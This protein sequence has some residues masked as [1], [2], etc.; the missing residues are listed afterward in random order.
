[1]SPASVGTPLLWTLFT[2]FVFFMLA[3]DLGVF[4]RRAHAVRLR[5]AAAW[6]AVWVGLAV[7][8]NLGVAHYFGSQKA[9]EFLTGYLIEWS[10]SV[11]NLFVFLVVFSYFNVPSRCQHRLLFWGILGALGMRAVLIAA[12]SLLVQRFHWILYVF[13]VILVV[14]ALRLLLS[15]EE[16][17]HPE[18]NP[19]VRLFRRLYP[20]TKD[21]EDC[22]LFVR[23]ER[24]W[25]AT[26]LFVVL[27]VVETTDLVF[28]LDSIPAIFAVTTDPFII[29]TSNVFAILGLRSLFF[30]LAGVMAYFRFL[31]IG[32]AGVLAFI[33]VKLL[34]SH[35]VAVPIGVSLGVI[36]SLLALS[37]LASVIL[38]R[39]PDGP[40]AAARRH[41]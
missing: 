9:L 40:A 38:P 11:D 22:R 13:G 4:H 41:P 33:G 16:G 14:T 8:F 3:L 18:R 27:L 20:V 25:W 34:I 2:L 5:E 10:L 32:L 37:V 21:Y 17:V 31:R 36:A 12:G 35:W 26:P 24:R 19:V 30:L 28:A 29:Y 6:S 23:R 1:M 7:A 39:R 15:S